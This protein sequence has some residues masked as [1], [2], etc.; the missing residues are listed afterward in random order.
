MGY[1][2]TTKPHLLHH[3]HQP[4]HDPT[5]IYSFGAAPY[6]AVNNEDILSYLKQ[7]Q[8]MSSP[9]LCPPEVAVLM[10]QCWS[11]SPTQRPVFADIKARLGPMSKMDVREYMQPARRVLETNASGGV[12]Y[13]AASGL[14]L[15]STCS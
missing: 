8:R 14:L 15:S 3:T 11:L 7:G 2:R 1:V 4:T 13:D 12:L 6:P 10:K 9:P 5:E